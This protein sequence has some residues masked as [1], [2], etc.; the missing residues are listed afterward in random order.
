MTRLQF[1]PFDKEKLV[2]QLKK[3]FPSYIVKKSFNTIQ[4]RKK[5]I[6]LSKAVEII[7]RP[8]KGTIRIRGHIHFL[9]VWIMISFPIAIYLWVKRK[10]TYALQEEVAFQLKSILTPLKNEQ[11]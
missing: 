10:H 4:V 1:A 6:T 11:P 9:I 3:V 7:P 2:E 8:K 5:K